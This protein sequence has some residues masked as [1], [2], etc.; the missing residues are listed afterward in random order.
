M[1]GR[2]GWRKN[3]HD[4][5]KLDDS[6]ATLVAHTRNLILF[7]LSG[8]QAISD[9]MTVRNMMRGR[10]P[11][12]DVHI[13]DI[14]QQIPDVFWQNASHRPTLH[15]SFASIALPP[16]VR[17]TRLISTSLTKLDEIEM[18]SAAGLPVPEA[19]L[20]KPDLNLD[21]D[22]WG[23]FTVIKPNRAMKGRGVHLLR[24]NDVRHFDS[25]KLPEDDPQRGKEFIA[26]RFI[27]TGPHVT[28]HRVMTLLGRPIYSATSTAVD[29]RPAL[30]S[31]GADALDVP[32]AANAMVRKMSL[33]ND[34]DMIEMATSLHAALPHLPVMGVDII[35]E[36]GTGKLFVLEFNSHGL[37]WHLSSKLGFKQQ[38][39]NG[40]DFYNQF[41]ALTTIADAL[42]D[43]TRELAT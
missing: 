18:I 3:A 33:C 24:T 17:G 12:I 25:N 6:R 41:N 19:H 36:H 32:I 26:Q 23:A 5:A 34:R 22:T 21:E 39:E 7:H 8:Y 10:A 4:W 20:I 14:K 40:I 35:R 15:F 43:A 31:G 30:E 28:C 13:V 16:S 9:Y 11:D 37:V 29:L 42:I 1:G 27:D 38:G 2:D